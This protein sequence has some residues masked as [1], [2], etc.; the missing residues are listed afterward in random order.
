LYI[1]EDCTGEHKRGL[2]GRKRLEEEQE[3]KKKGSK[4]IG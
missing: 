3:E 2:Q 4:K 1:H